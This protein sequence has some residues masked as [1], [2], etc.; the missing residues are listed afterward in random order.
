MLVVANAARVQTCCFRDPSHER[1]QGSHGADEASR[2]P[3]PSHC[4]Y[5]PTISGKIERLHKTLRKEFF[6]EQTF[7]TIE[8]AQAG[9]D[10]WVEHHNRVREHQGIGEVPR[11]RLF[12]LAARTVFE[13]V[14]GEMEI[15]EARAEAEPRDTGT[16][17]S[18]RSL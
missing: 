17:T 7:G 6:S 4:P 16:E 9:L 1:A 8:K 12:E 18:Q 5:S 14:N 10:L 15:S 13:V 11:I 3:S 2:D